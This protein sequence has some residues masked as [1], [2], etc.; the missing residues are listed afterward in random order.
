M[1][2]MNMIISL[3]EGTGLPVIPYF[4]SNQ[5]PKGQKN[6]KHYSSKEKV[7]VN[8][9]NVLLNIIKKEQDVELSQVACKTLV[10]V[11]VVDHEVTYKIHQ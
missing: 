10:T 4:L 6:S 5:S 11:G 8:L 2:T 7:D 9:L 3:V 1:E